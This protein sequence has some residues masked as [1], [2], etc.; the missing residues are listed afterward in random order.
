MKLF[1]GDTVSELTPFLTVLLWVDW[2]RLMSLLIS[3]GPGICNLNLRFIECENGR[4]IYACGVFNV[5]SSFCLL[6]WIIWSICL[7]YFSSLSRVLKLNALAWFL[8]LLRVLFI[9]IGFF[10]TSI[11]SLCP[12]FCLEDNWLYLLELRK[13]WDEKVSDY[14]VQSVFDPTWDFNT[15]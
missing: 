11:S 3:I 9:L 13:F 2:K 14:C 4:F 10:A 7:M 5:S 12:W 8:I 1:L 15:S 6:L